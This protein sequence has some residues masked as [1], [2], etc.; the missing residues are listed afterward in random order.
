MN[1][2]QCQTCGNAIAA[3]APSGLCPI[4]LLRTAIEHGSSQALAPLLPKLH[5]FGDYELLEEI[6]RGGMGVVYRAKQL[7]LDRIVALKMMRPGLLSSESE[8]QR[9]LSEA[10]T[11]ASLRHPNIVAIHEAGEFDGLHYFSMD[12][13]EGPNLSEIVRAGALSPAEAARYVQVLAE[14]VHYAH[15][16]GILHRD[17]KPSNVLVDAGG[18]PCI[19]DFGLA[20]R[21][22]SDGTNPGSGTIIGTP[23]YM[24]PEQASGH[25]RRITAAS[26]VYSLGAILYELL[27]GQPPFRAGS[28][29]EIVRMV[30]DTEPSRPGLVNPA[31][32]AQIEAIC[33][34]CLAKEPA[35]RFQSANELSDD[36][37]RFLCG[38]AVHAN[39]GTSGQH[40]F[41]RSPWFLVA[42]CLLTILISWS[43]LRTP[44]RQDREPPAR[45]ESLGIAKPLPNTPDTPPEKPLAIQPLPIHKRTVVSATPPAVSATPPAISQTTPA[46]LEASVSP[47]SGLGYDQVFSFLYPSLPELETSSE[48][49]VDFFDE[50]ALD[51]RHCNMLIEPSTGRVE[52]QFDP[53][54]G[55]ALRVSGN[56][57]TLSRIENSICAID[58][59]GVSLVSQA[60][61]AE[62]RLPMTFKHSFDGAKTIESWVRKKPGGARSETTLTGQWTVGPRP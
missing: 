58:L 10:R 17:L 20:R 39:I 42:A 12:F 1:L 13:V 52:L 19:T 48:L 14:T 54:R 28:Q 32:D 33:M 21:I 18:R 57:G 34:Q 29:L 4:C 22:D 6:A 43:V 31:V 24:S 16:K 55:P 53:R 44:S 41:V 26:D 60:S 11:A 35:K 38:D 2:L 62:L 61:G 15:T 36:L 3:D 9:F 23:A 59:S 49:E 7:S 51:A 45:P 37:K 40:R 27:T 25:A 8:I 50:A 47:G 5:Y 46:P 56:L 30:L